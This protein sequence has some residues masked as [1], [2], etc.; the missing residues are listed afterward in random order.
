VSSL[1]CSSGLSADEDQS[2]LCM[3]EALKHGINFFDNAEAYA[4]GNSE[5]VMGKTFQKWFAEGLSSCCRNALS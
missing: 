1:K 4:N 2:H 3:T 5:I